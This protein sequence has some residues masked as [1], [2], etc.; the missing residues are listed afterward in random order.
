[1]IDTHSHIYEPVFRA[2]R[3]D[4]I[5]RAKQAGV[6]LIL[7]PNINAE[8]IEQMLDLCYRYPDYCFPMMGLHPTD[9]EE[10]YK[11]V[12]IDME[13][14]LK[15]PDQP[16]IA[17]GEVGLDYY[18]DK[19][20]AKEQEETFRVQIEWAIKYHLPLMIHSRS[21]HRQLVTAISEYKGEEISG[22]FHCFGGTKDEALELLQFPGFALGI[23]GVV[24]Y[25]NSPL[26][27]TLASVPL[28]RIVL[29]TDSPYLAPVPYR[30]KRNESSYLAE[31]LQKVA[32]IYNVS[33]KQA[34]SVTNNNA[35]RI[36]QRLNKL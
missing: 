30:G 9:I 34:E 3:E 26:P 6:E 25:K 23:G 1:M 19:S 11:Q 10:D 28:E 4:V 16:Y 2:D 27:E 32:Q 20:K 18:W 31:V 12:L 8:S 24:T 7:L 17:I 35:R 5:M 22:V 13:A 33:E 15:A 36:F 29:E 21:A 14:L